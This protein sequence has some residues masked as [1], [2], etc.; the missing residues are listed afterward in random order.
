MAGIPER[1]WNIIQGQWELAKDRTDEADAMASAYEELAEQ[2]RSRPL[3]PGSRS[4]THGVLPELP[5]PKRG[6]HDPFEASYALLQVS[7]GSGLADLDAAY[8][9]RLAELGT[10][11]FPEGSAQRQVLEGRRHAL[12]AAYEKLRDALNPTETRFEKI[13]F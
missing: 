5:A 11:Q 8:Q 13:E 1:I 12:E 7:P 10:E 2:I 9:A 3:P 6:A 4:L